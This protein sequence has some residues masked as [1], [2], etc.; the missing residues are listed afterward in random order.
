MLAIEGLSAQDVGDACQSWR[1]QR[2]GRAKH[3]AYWRTLVEKAMR[4]AEERRPADP[5][6]EFADDAAEAGLD[7]SLAA[8][9]RIRNVAILAEHIRDEGHVKVGSDERLYR[10]DGGAYVPDG[11]R[12]CRIRTRELLGSRVRAKIVA[13]VVSLQRTHPVEVGVS[14][15]RTDLLCVADGLLDWQAGELRPHSPDFITTAQIPVRWRPDAECP[16]IE[17]FLADVLPPDARELFFEVLG[18]AIYPANPMQK[19]VLL[20]GQGGNGKGVALRLIEALV[21]EGNFSS[22][23]LQDLG[24]NRFA[25]AGLYGKLANICGDIDRRTVERSGLFKKITGGDPIEAEHKNKDRF[26]FTCRA[27]PIFSANESPPASDQTDGWF[28][29]WVIIPFPNKFR[30]TARE[31]VGLAA[32]LT[33]ETELEGLLARAVDGLR[34]LMARGRFDMPAS[35]RAEAEEYRESADSVRAFVG[36]WCVFEGSAWTKRLTLYRGY[37]QFC[38][39]EGRLPMKAP[40]FYR[41]LLDG[42]PGEVALRTIKGDRGFRGIRMKGDRRARVDF[43]DEIASV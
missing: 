9:P 42:Y 21:G 22:V 24:E 35:V 37:E 34:R 3:R 17:R 1:A 32:K 8:A 10:Y 40:S 27:V 29:R 5:R 36:E 43:S 16:L 26:K 7:G 25:C 33:S 15:P 23:S 19:A 13:E 38:R 6:D 31:D 12:Y 39:D 2:G 11:E 14:A 4:A 28:D 18:L 20:L 41:Q 30:G